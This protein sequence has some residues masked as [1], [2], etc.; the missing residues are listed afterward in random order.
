MTNVF[1]VVLQNK[2]FKIIKPNLY[3]EK[4]IIIQQNPSET[5]DIYF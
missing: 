2:R 5:I 1:L 3:L 4:N